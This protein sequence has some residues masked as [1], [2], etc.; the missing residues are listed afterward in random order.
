MS[1]PIRGGGS[2]RPKDLILSL[3]DNFG[4]AAG[5]VNVVVA[6]A[7][8]SLHL[9]GRLRGGRALICIELGAVVATAAFCTW[10]LWRTRSQEPRDVF[11]ASNDE[12]LFEVHKE[13]SEKDTNCCGGSCGCSGSG[14]VEANE[15]EQ[16]EGDLEDLQSSGD[17]DRSVARAAARATY[18]QPKAAR[19]RAA[20]QVRSG[21]LNG[22]L[23]NGE[24][25]LCST[26]PV[27]T[28]SNDETSESLFLPGRAKVFFK[29]FG[30][31]HNVSDSEYMRK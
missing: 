6:G 28:Y 20:R 26:P 7:A 12:R 1:I 18:V 2:M 31:S 13:A 19:M 29:T 22:G 24:T 3:R 5:A 4:S 27:S 9:S 14:P 17:E 30:C 15:A 25:D 11:V 23:E 10:R 8:A 16:A 21:S